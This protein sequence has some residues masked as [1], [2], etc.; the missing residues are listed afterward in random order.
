[1]C[2]ILD[3]NEDSFTEENI[4]KIDEIKTA[5]MQGEQTDFE[6]RWVSKS[7]K[8]VRTKI[9]DTLKTAVSEEERLVSKRFTTFN[10]LNPSYDMESLTSRAFYSLQSLVAQIKMN[11]LDDQLKEHRIEMLQT[12]Y[13]LHQL[14]PTTSAEDKENSFNRLQSM[15]ERA[16]VVEHIAQV[17]NLIQAGTEITNYHLFLAIGVNS[18]K[19][20]DKFINW[21]LD[22]NAKM[23]KTQTSTDYSFLEIACMRGQKASKAIDALIKHGAD[24]TLLD[25]SGEAPIN[26]A[27]TSDLSSNEVIKL[28]E[29]MENLNFCDGNSESLLHTAINRIKYRNDSTIFNHLLDQGA[30]PNIKNSEG[31]TPLH[32]VIELL[33][34]KALPHVKKLILQGG[35]VTTLD[36]NDQTLLH[37]AARQSCLQSNKGIKDSGDLVR[38]LIN[39]G[40]KVNMMDNEGRTALHEAVGFGMDAENINSVEELIKAG[41][42]LDLRDDKGNTPLHVAADLEHVELVRILLKLGPNRNIRNDAGRLPGAMECISEKS[43]E[44]ILELLANI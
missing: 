19:L 31:R 1:M 41:A 38:F 6:E 25:S 5:L 20:V 30:T 29:K 13:K 44:Q 9:L 39:N 12:M 3:C 42:D 17:N 2:R 14:S 35:V 16:I 23:K 24:L 37:Y 7:Y 32:S 15:L 34:E 26:L 43:K 27:I 4:K 21:G 22:P 40:A 28:I 18:D 11:R 8:N 10:E 33:E 36:N